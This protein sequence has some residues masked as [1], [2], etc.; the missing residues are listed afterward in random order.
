MQAIA[1]AYSIASLLLGS[2]VHSGVSLPK[3]GSFLN[4][5]LCKSLKASLSEMR[6]A[7]Y[8]KAICST[9]ADRLSFDTSS[10]QQDR[11]GI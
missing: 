6:T 1:M 3:L 2:D 7:D 4:D 9:T 5:L 10:T 11:H 8:L